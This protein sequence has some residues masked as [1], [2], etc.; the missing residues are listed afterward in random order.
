MLFRSRGARAPG[1]RIQ[2]SG[3]GLAITQELVR[4]HE[5]SI[6]LLDASTGAHFRVRLPISEVGA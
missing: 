5:G 4:A 6:E 2:G 1:E 3:L